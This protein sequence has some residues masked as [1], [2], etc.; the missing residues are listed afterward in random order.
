MEILEIFD[1]NGIQIY[2]LDRTRHMTQCD[3][4]SFERQS[5][6]LEILALLEI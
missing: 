2:H 6:K 3:V 4:N 1:Q 5:I